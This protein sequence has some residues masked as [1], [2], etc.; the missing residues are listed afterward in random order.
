MGQFKFLR[1]D[2][3]QFCKVIEAISWQPDVVFQVGIGRDHKETEVILEKWP[4]VKFF[5]TEPHPGLQEML[6]K[7]KWLYPGEIYPVALRNFEG[8]APFHT[9]SKHKSGS[10][11]FPFDW[12]KPDEIYGVVVVRVTTLDKLFSGGPGTGRVLLWIDCE[13]TEL[14]AL[15][16]GEQFIKGVD[17]VHA[18]MTSN[19]K[20]PGWCKP[21][22]VHRWLLQH[23]FMLQ[24][25]HPK[26]VEDG[27]CNGIYVR[28]HLFR[29]EFCCCPFFSENGI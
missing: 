21:A 8:T 24:W 14:D 11:F 18:E 22:D 12:H 25:I 15:K 6:R 5:G 20:G 29:P 16:G 19:P 9:K 26:N 17:V 2:S 4:D 3:L 23:G 10:S 13:G 28:T 7:P 27:Q 1:Q